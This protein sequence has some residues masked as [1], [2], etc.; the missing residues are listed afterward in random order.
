[1]VIGIGGGANAELNLLTLW[2]KRGRIHASRL[3]A[4]PLEEKARCVQLVEAHVLPFLRDDKQ[5]LQVPVAATYP[6]SE[7][8]AAYDRFVAGGKLG[9]IVLTRD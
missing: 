5:S 1:M 6:M 2:A 3:R 7:A 8:E 9:K 4:R